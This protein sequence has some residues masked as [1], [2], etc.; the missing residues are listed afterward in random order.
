MKEPKIYEK[1]NDYQKPYEE[2]D[3][4]EDDQFITN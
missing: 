4:N 3:E 2:F 1:S